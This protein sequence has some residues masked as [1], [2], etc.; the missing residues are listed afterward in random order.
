M[1]L[2]DLCEVFSPYQNIQIGDSKT[3][4]PLGYVTYLAD[5]GC[6]IESYEDY[7]VYGIA[8]KQSKA[9]KMYLAILLVMKV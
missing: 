2:K 3:G 1:K 8:P 6:D 5:S 9:G 7:E 4:E